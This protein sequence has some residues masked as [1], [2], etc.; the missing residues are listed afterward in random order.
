M[1]FVGIQFSPRLRVFRE[2]VFQ[3]KPKLYKVKDMEVTSVGK[4]KVIFSP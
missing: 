4:G 2:A 1:N 3:D